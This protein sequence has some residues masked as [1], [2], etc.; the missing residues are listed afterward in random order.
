MSSDLLLL[1]LCNA[2]PE[3]RGLEKY[4]TEEQD[5][6]YIF[7]PDYDTAVRERLEENAEFFLNKMKSKWD[8][9]KN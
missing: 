6:G 2:D 4:V 7:P 1:F 5:I 9:S 8:Y 3:E